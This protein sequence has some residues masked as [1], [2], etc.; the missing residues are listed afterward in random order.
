M[1]NVIWYVNEERQKILDELEKLP[2]Y[3]R[4]KRSEIIEQALREY[5]EKHGDGNPQFR[6]EQ[7]EDPNFVACPAFFR[8]TSHFGKY[9]ETQ[10][11]EQLE[12]FK[13]QLIM[14]DRILGR[15]L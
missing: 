15:Y 10:S 4:R 11:P 12:N 14:I 6:L 8:D 1:T 9:L 2:D 5:V 3:G 7:F 13:N